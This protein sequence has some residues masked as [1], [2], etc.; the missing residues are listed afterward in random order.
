MSSC[1][2]TNYYKKTISGSYVS[3]K[4]VTISAT[5]TASAT[6][7]T[8]SNTNITADSTI[9]LG[10]PTGITVANYDLL[11]NAKIVCTAQAEGTAIFTALG[12]APTSAVEFTVTVVN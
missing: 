4:P 2:A 11:A 7:L 8:V 1:S 9:F 6:T 3:L 10:V 12:T 5:W